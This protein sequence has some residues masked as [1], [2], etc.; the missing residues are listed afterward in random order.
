MLFE[1]IPEDFK[2][3]MHTYLKNLFGSIQK[4]DNNILSFNDTLY[5]VNIRT[6]HCKLEIGCDKHIE[7]MIELFF[8]L[9]VFHKYSKEKQFFY[10][11]TAGSIL[12]HYKMGSLLPWDDD[13]DIVVPFSQFMHIKD[14]WNNTPDKEKNVWDKN[15]TYKKIKIN[16]YDIVI[17]KLNGKN[18]YK[19]K[20]NVNSIERR[21]QYQLDIGGL[22]I[23]SPN[24]FQQ[25]LSSELKTTILE[26]KE[27]YHLGY[28]C[29][30][31]TYLLKRDTAELLLNE[32]YPRWR[33]MK[34]PI[35][36]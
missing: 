26:N 30:I 11:I 24:G 18:F 29:N 16:S 3:T 8:L 19:L 36:F 12:G 21:G 20:L 35:L 23:F 31:E 7:I 32:M 25:T 15:W 34:H 4:K 6:D 2:N 1:S 14:L 33:E 10:S 27:K 17:L 22:D 28:F 9:D 13:I 5:P